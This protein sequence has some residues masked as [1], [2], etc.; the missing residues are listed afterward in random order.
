MVQKFKQNKNKYRV[1]LLLKLPAYEHRR[2]KLKLNTTHLKC[3]YVF[4]S[5]S[6]KT[7]L[8]FLN[9]NWKTVAEEF[10]KP[11]VDYAV[12]LAI[13]TIE[14]FFDKVPYNELVYVPIPT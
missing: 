6:G 11:I 1:Q 4:L 2:R 10:G 14:K 13:R 3:I 12:D 7:V 9:D 5:I 8:Q